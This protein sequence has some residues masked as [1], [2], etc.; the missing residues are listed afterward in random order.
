MMGSALTHPRL[1]LATSAIAIPCEIALQTVHT[2]DEPLGLL[3]EVK[4]GPV[5]REYTKYQLYI[6]VGDHFA[7]CDPKYFHC[8]L[9]VSNDCFSTLGNLS[10]CSIALKGVLQVAVAGSGHNADLVA[11]GIWE[12]FWPHGCTGG[13]LFPKAP[14][15]RDF[16]EIK[17]YRAPEMQKLG[18][19]LQLT[20]Y[21]LRGDGGIDKWD[22]VIG[23]NQT[24]ENIV[25]TEVEAS[26]D[27]RLYIR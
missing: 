8:Y 16:P 23:E 22:V 11:E 4:L 13:P 27:I 21:S 10:V 19:G 25:I 14:F 7:A 9:K 6:T 20:F 2:N 26:N 12:I 3:Q 5:S 24:I 17:K 1:A 18:N 15:Q